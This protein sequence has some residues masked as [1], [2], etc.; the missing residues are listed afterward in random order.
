MEVRFT[1]LAVAQSDRERPGWAPRSPRFTER[2]T[3][4]AAVQRAS[5][6]RLD[7]SASQTGRSPMKLVLKHA[8]VS[9]GP[10]PG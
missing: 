7:G 2:D 8:E 3:S 5:S 10:L 6:S 1:L 4:V 9:A